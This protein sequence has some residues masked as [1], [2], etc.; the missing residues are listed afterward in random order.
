MPITATQVEEAASRWGLSDVV[1]GVS[2][3][4]ATYGNLLLHWNARLS[5]TSIRNEDELIERHLMEG[6]FAAAHHPEASRALDFGSGTGVPL[7]DGV[8]STAPSPR[9]DTEPRNA[10]DLSVIWLRTFLLT[11][12]VTSTWSPANAIDRRLPIG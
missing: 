3:R 7:P 9:S 11:S 6:V 4:L 2:D 8:M 1:E 10:T 12:K 5:L